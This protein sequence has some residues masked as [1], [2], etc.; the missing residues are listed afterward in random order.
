[1]SS[2]PVEGISRDDWAW[3]EGTVGSCLR[4]NPAVGAARGAR[5]GLVC[6][7]FNGSITLRL[8]RGALDALEAGGISGKMV[9]V[10]W[11]PGAFEIPITARRMARNGGFDAIVCLGA[12]IRGGTPH[13]DYVAGECA[14]GIRQVGLETDTPVIFGVLT[15]DN[16]EQAMERSGGGPGNKG[17]ESVMVGLE[18]VDLLGR[19]LAATGRR[20]S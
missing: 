17:Y 6:S 11:V 7:A 13:F 12:V 20:S 9:T 5:L 3:L 18:M 15:T 8:L 4:G 10:S 2:D 14:A 16:L 1:M 19:Q